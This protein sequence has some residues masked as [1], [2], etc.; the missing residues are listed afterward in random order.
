GDVQGAFVDGA[1]GDGADDAGGLGGQ[2][3]LDVAEVVDT[4]GSDHRDAAGGSQGGGGFDVAA[5]HHPVLGDVGVDDG[6]HAVGLEATGQVDRLHAGDFRPAVGG[7]ESVLGVQAD[8][9]LAREGLAGLGDELGFLH[10][11]GADD[12][13]ADAGLDVVLDGFQRADAAA[14]LD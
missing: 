3:L 12:H 5:L 2:Q 4:T 11:L 6:G 1:A 7:D 13:V 8:D 14:D 10:R 9:D